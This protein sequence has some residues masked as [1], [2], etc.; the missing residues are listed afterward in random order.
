MFQCRQVNGQNLFVRVVN[1]TPD[2]RALWFVDGDE[3]SSSYAFTNLL[4][5]TVFQPHE[6]CPH[7]RVLVLLANGDEVYDVSI[8]H[9][10][11][12]QADQLA[13]YIRSLC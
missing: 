7:A 10:D 8:G 12:I 3:D 5:I 13:S 9:T 1:V 11:P 2:L 6:F 4:G